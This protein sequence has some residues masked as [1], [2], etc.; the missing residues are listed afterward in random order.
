[1]V[2]AALTA[3]ALVSL[4][5]ESVN[6]QKSAEDIAAAWLEQVNLF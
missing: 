3:D 6:E 4:N 1:M 5:S 2:S